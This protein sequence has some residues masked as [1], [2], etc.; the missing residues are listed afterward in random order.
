M[1]MWLMKLHNVYDSIKYKYENDMTFKWYIDSFFTG[2]L[3]K[4]HFHRGEFV[5]GL[6]IVD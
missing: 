6:D 5:L 4:Y 1:S 3:W 2:P